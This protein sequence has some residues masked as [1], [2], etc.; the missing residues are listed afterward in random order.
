MALKEPES[1][2]QLIYFTNR[3]VGSGW[4]TAWVYKGLCPKCK[5]GKMGK[6]VDKKTG[7]VKIRAKEYECPECGFSQEKKEHEETLECE[8]KYT[9]P[10]CKFKGEIVVP[11]KRK[12]FEGMKAIVFQCEKCK[13]KIPITKKLKEKSEAGADDED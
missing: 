10:A 5:K 8:I 9:C 12:S 11:Y 13:T 1:M 2:E 7:K 6:P 4:A 3:A